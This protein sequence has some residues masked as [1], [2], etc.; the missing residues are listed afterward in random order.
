[1]PS[2]S[3][4]AVFRTTTQYSVCIILREKQHM[5]PNGK[6][7][8]ASPGSNKITYRDDMV[9]HSPEDTFDSEPR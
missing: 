9:V 6:D 4:E 2:Y 5:G 3:V 1:M 8:H 7:V